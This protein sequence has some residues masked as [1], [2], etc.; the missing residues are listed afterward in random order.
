RRL[1]QGVSS[2]IS[3]TCVAGV[4]CSR[5]ETIF[6]LFSNPPQESPKTQGFFEAGQVGYQ[7]NLSFNESYARLRSSATSISASTS[8]AGGSLC[9]SSS[10]SAFVW[11][12]IDVLKLQELF[13]QPFQVR[14][15]P[16]KKTAPP[17]V[18]LTAY[19]DRA[20]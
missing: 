14:W 8:S 3:M 9:T 18:Q 17:M 11:D 2:A 4:P 15:H 13:V 16:S 1:K 12:V 10:Y 7:V 6:A 20:A 5:N 19:T